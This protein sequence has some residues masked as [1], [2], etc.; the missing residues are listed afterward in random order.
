MLYLYMPAKLNI[1]IPTPCHENW[2]GMSVAKK[3]RFCDSCQKTVIDFTQSSDRQ[4]AELFKKESNVCGRFLNSQLE[5]DLVIPK[6]KS[7]L[8]IAASAVAMAFFSGGSNEVFAQDAKVGTVQSSESSHRKE[9]VSI[10]PRTITGKVID[11]DSV[12]VANALILNKT[13]GNS[14]YTDIYGN[15]KITASTDDLLEISGFN[16]EQETIK[17]NNQ[18]KLIIL[19]NR[20]EFKDMSYT[21]G[22]AQAI[23]VYPRRLSYVGYLFYR[24]GNIFRKK[25]RS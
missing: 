14:Y 9:I 5:R 3:G 12:T 11:E 22:G 7:S 15:F 1:S 8:W 18:D 13:S 19:M 2:Q 24:I 4:I 20:A 10:A 21:L 23:V 16:Y 6:E 17:V 25:D